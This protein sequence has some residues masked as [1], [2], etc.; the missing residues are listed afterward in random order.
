MAMAW[1]SFPPQPA[2]SIAARAALKSS[3]KECKWRMDRWIFCKRTGFC[4]IRFEIDLMHLVFPDEILV[5]IVEDPVDKLTALGGAV[6]LCQIDVFIDGDFGRD[7]LEIK[8]FGHS[9]LHEDHIEGG[10]TVGVPVL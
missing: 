8:E 6:V 2:R 9:H 1:L 7:G 5:D 3:E 4:L 10:D